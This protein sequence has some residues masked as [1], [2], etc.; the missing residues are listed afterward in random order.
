CFFPEAMVSDSTDTMKRMTSQEFIQPNSEDSLVA[1][2]FSG[3]AGGRVIENPTEA[4]SAE[5]EEGQ[6]WRVRKNNFQCCQSN[7][8]SEPWTSSVHKTHPWFHGGLS[9]KEAERLIEKQ[10][11]ADG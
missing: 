5:Q 2:D 1:M 10:G 7:M 9:R 3:K 6:A 8:N 4:Q 11:L